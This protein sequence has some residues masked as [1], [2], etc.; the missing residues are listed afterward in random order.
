MPDK[1]Q[2]GDEGDLQEQDNDLAPED[3]S[4]ND[5]EQDEQDEKGKKPEKKE[6]TN[7]ERLARENKEIKKAL[8]T[9]NRKVSE[10]ENRLTKLSGDSK[11]TPEDL[12]TQLAERERKLAARDMR[13]RE[14]QVEIA[15][16][17]YLADNHKGWEDGVEWLPPKVMRQLTEEDI[18]EDGEYDEEALDAAIEPLARK[19]VEK[20]P[21]QTQQSKERGKDIP[22]GEPN[23]SQSNGSQQKSGRDSLPDPFQKTLAKIEGR[24]VR[25]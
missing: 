7:E 24:T 25:G 5:D 2:S 17:K 8:R 6:E 16:A 15:V 4:D 10:F 18:T 1:Q 11:E 19:Y 3:E 20:N 23:R 12:A 9:A 21:R 14:Q 22:G 13:L